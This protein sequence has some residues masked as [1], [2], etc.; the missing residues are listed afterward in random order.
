[1]Q[2]D[3]KGKWDSFFHANAGRIVL[4]NMN[5]FVQNKIQELD[6]EKE[7]KFE[8]LAMEQQLQQAKE[9]EEILIAMNKKDREDMLKAISEVRN[10]LSAPDIQHMNKV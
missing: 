9:E 6:R 10:L 3:F 1:L 5:V 2:N 8:R 4:F 7:K